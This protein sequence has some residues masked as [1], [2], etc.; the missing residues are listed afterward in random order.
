M[1][2]APAAPQTIAIIGAGMAGAALAARL[3]ANGRAPTVFDKSRGLGGR[4]AT[5]RAGAFAFDHGAP[6]FDPAHTGP[7]FAEAS[8]RWVADGK[9][10][11]WEGEGLVGL[12]AMSAPARALFEGTT[13][14]TAAEIREAKRAD[15][16]WTLHTDA[17]QHG[18]FTTLLVAIPAPQARRIL[19]D[20]PPGLASATYDPGWTLMLGFD[21]PTGREAARTD[22]PGPALS[23]CLNSGSKPGRPGECFVLHARAE[24]SRAHLELDRDDACNRL[25]A[26]AAPLFPTG[27]S[28]A[29]ATAHRWRFARVAEPLGQPCLWDPDRQLGFA[30][31]WC[32]GPNV[33][34][35]FDSGTALANAVLAG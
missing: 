20:A 18:P 8:A 15:T 2:N 9:A 22:L 11:P 7:G 31:D 32:L 16:G 10:A 21:A 12:P 34:H 19:P 5:R 1:T 6:A 4:M 25:M 17:A 26:E 24:W 29:Y 35:A 33:S 30:G 14:V 23:V 3:R 13:I 27:L 28:P